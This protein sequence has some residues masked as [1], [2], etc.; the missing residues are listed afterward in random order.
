M[1]SRYSAFVMRD[2]DY[3]LKTWHPDTRPQTLLLDEEPPPKWL[4]LTIKRTADIDEQH[5]EVEFVARYKINGRAFRMH[6]T[7]RFV[8]IDGRW[9]YLEGELK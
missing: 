7:S 2:A 4:E 6:E 5:A 1:R 3:L 8:R 9:F